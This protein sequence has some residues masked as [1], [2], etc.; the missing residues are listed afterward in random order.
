MA[1]SS[2][3]SKS[4]AKAGKPVPSLP[5]SKD[6]AALLA[7]LLSG[8]SWDEIG[9]TV[10]GTDAPAS[11]IPLRVV[12]RE[13]LAT[14]PAANAKAGK[15]AVAP[16]SADP[17]AIRAARDEAGEGFPL[18]AARILAGG[19]RLTVGAVRRLYAEG[20]G[21]SLDGRVYVGA[22][23]RTLVRGDERIALDGP[24]PEE[25]PSE[26]KAERK[27]RKA[28]KRAKRDAKAARKAA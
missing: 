8:A 21:V 1:K 15:Y 23:G 7:A 5:L 6:G 27:A 11:A 25:T 24:T 3:S 28:A 14:N 20:E 26:S 22:N 10:S 17:A 13:Y 12:L 2:K 16:L 4:P 18:I 9:R 19:T